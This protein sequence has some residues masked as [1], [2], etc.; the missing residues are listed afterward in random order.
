MGGLPDRLRRGDHRSLIA[1]HVFMKHPGFIGDSVIGRRVDI[2]A[3]CSTTALRCDR[4]PVAEPAIEEITVN[5]DG[6][7]ITTGQRK[8]GVVVGDE[9]AL[10]AGTVLAPGTRSGPPP[11]ST[12]TTTSAASC[13]LVSDQVRAVTATSTRRA[14]VDAALVRVTGGRPLSGR[15]SVQGSKIIALHLYAATLLADAPIV[16]TGVPQIID[17]H[18]CAQIL[19]HTGARVGGVPSFGRPGALRDW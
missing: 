5:L 6:Q 1:G 14:A 16:L 8:F 7:R 19:R 3:F 10:P 18:V 2:G 13:P 11:S 17:T 4:G 15:I 12:P 9:V